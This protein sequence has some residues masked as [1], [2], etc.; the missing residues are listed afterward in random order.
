MWTPLV[1]CPVGKYVYSLNLRVAPPG[2]DNT[3]ANGLMMSC[4]F[5][6]LAAR[7][8][9]MVYAGNWGTW[10][11]WSAVLAYHRVVGTNTRY[12]NPCGACDDTALNGLYAKL[13]TPF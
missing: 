2:G 1:S 9:H 13:A 5:P 3:A 10:R 7:T 12:Q 11:G 8:A 4:E 6:N